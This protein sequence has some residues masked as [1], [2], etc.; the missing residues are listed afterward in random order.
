MAATD[1]SNP[2]CWATCDRCG[3]VGN[4]INLNFQYDWAGTR[5]INKRILVCDKCLDDPSE[6]A[7]RTIVLPPDP[8]FIANTRPEQYAIDEGLMPLTTERAYPG[9]PGQVIRDENGDYI[10]VE[11]EE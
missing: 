10:G 8:P 4:L 6:A 3:W 9:D 5:L 7:R 2:R 1:P 11:P